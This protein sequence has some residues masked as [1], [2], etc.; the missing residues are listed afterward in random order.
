MSLV[1]KWRAGCPRHAHAPACAEMHHALDASVY[2]IK[3]N[4]FRS[5]CSPFQIVHYSARDPCLIAVELIDLRIVSTV[6]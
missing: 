3:R 5:A 2:W 1:I 4:G 6:L